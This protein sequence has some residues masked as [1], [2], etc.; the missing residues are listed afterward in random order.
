L[1][2]NDV[3]VKFFSCVQPSCFECRS[4]TSCIIKSVIRWKWPSGLTCRCF[5]PHVLVGTESW[6]T[7]SAEKDRKS[8]C[9]YG[10]LIVQ[11]IGTHL[12]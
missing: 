2:V 8:L 11:S 12:T 4:E 3:K 1:G 7:Y 10:E 6:H 9:G 5:M